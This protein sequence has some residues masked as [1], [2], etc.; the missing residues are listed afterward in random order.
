MVWVSL[1]DQYLVCLVPC[2]LGPVGGGLPQP[3]PSVFTAAEQAEGHA[4]RDMAY[5]IQK[6]NV[7]SSGVFPILLAN[8]RVDWFGIDSMLLPGNGT[9]DQWLDFL[10]S[11]RHFWPSMTT[12]FASLTPLSETTFRRE[13]RR[14]QSKHLWDIVNLDWNALARKLYVYKPTGL[15]R[16]D[17][18][19]LLFV[20]KHR[21]N[22]WKE[23]E[24]RGANWKEVR[25]AREQAPWEWGS[26]RPVEPLFALNLQLL[27][28][29]LP[30]RMKLPKT[31]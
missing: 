9:A 21:A 26:F 25:A 15:S 31:Y 20:S 6:W 27:F 3:N 8:A 22:P 7:K 17:L 12:R 16:D 2:K 14:L 24:Y 5:K 28:K 11:Q 30:M 18:W 29:A 19:Q 10:Q 13:R 4:S 23:Q 1:L